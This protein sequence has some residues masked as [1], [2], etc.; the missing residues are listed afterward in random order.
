[1]LVVYF[2]FSKANGGGRCGMRAATG[3]DA[4]MFA[5]WFAGFQNYVRCVE[6]DL[7]V[8]REMN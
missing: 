1:M 7:K 3:A 4:A 5:D 2:V 6:R 8:Q